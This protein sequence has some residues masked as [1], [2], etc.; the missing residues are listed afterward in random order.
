MTAANA[1]VGSSADTSRNW[2]A[3]YGAS[4]MAPSR[5]EAMTTVSDPSPESS[6]SLQ[7]PFPKSSWFPRM[8]EPTDVSALPI[9]PIADEWKSYTL[10]FRF[11]EHLRL[12][13]G[14]PDMTKIS[15]MFRV[16]IL[17]HRQSDDKRLTLLDS[18]SKMRII[19]TVGDLSAL[20]EDATGRRFQ[21]LCLLEGKLNPK[22]L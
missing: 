2:M 12:S 4:G 7:N 22:A 14:N 6:K 16:R 9:P 21:G 20:L 15:Y 5:S 19:P 1:N 18:A 17:R 13:M 10:T 3:R 8:T 11:V